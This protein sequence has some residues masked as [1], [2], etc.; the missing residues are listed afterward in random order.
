MKTQRSAR[1]PVRCGQVQRQKVRER[2]SL[3][4]PQQEVNA[5]AQLT[6]RGQDTWP[7]ADFGKRTP[8]FRLF[9]CFCEKTQSQQGQMRLL[10]DS[11][12]Y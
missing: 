5:Y 9:V 3:T 8:L 10:L 4:L 12:V 2:W 6:S 11:S 1:T 7:G